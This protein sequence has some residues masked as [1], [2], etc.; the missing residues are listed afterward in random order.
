MKTLAV[1]IIFRNGYKIELEETEEDV[2][3]SEHLLAEKMIKLLNSPYIRQF[4]KNSR[5]K[6]LKN[7][8]I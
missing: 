7:Y 4:G 8:T 5:N 2:E 3:L 6:F 1:I